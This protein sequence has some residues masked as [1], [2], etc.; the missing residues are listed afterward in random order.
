[1]RSALVVLALLSTASTVSAAEMACPEI[2]AVGRGERVDPTIPE[3]SNVWSVS[4][5]RVRYQGRIAIAYQAGIPMW[6]GTAPTSDYPPA[7]EARIKPFKLNVK[8]RKPRPSD[9]MFEWVRRGPLAGDWN[10]P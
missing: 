8:W 6:S 3:Q 1:M 10:C 4:A 5:L 7:Y 2:L 9:R